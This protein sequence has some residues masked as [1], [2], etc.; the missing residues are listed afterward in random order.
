[1][2]IRMFKKGDVLLIAAISVLAVLFFGWNT[3]GARFSANQQLT[4]VIKHDGQV[5]QHINLSSV[6]TTETLTFNYEGI[7]QV[8]VAEKG[9]IR[10]SESDCP[11]K[12]CVKTGWLNKPGDKAVC[13]P[14][15]VVITI[16]GENNKVDSIAY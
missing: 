15:K 4:A 14:S 9:R 6:N 13:M 3:Y 11:D 10:F 12:I 2:N 1:M 16:V 8:I 7:R 5:I